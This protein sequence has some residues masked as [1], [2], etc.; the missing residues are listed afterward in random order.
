MHGELDKYDVF[1]LMFQSSV[2]MCVCVCGVGVCV[3]VCVYMC[4]VLIQL[5]NLNTATRYVSTCAH[6][7]CEVLAQ[8]PWA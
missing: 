7:G 8:Y 5:L 4:T 3:R 6:H 2:C 1:R